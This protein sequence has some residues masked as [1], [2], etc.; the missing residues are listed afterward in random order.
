MT[1]VE[2][3]IGAAL[4]GGVGLVAAKLMGDQASNQV[5]LK[6]SAEVASM[7]SKVEGL[8]N[9]PAN[10]KS[11]LS[12][13]IISASPGTPMG[14]SGTTEATLMALGTMHVLGEANYGTFT[15]PDNGIRLERSIYGTAIT[16]LVITF[17]MN[18]S[19]I[20]SRH[21]DQIIRRIP[22][23][24]QDDTGSLTN[25]GP[26][27]KTAETVGQKKMCDSLGGAAAWNG[28]KC[29]LNQV[30]CDPGQVVTKM[31]SLGGII[32]EDISTQ[33]NLNE[34][35]DLNGVSCIGKPNIYIENTGTKLKVNCAAGACTPVNGAWSA[36]GPYGACSGGY[37]WRYRNCNNPIPSCGGASCVGSNSS[38]STT[39][40]GGCF[41]A[42][43]QIAMADGSAKNIED[44]LKGDQLQDAHSK[45][46]TVQKLLRR[47][48]WGD[49]H[50]INGGPYFFT[51]NH[52]F[53]TVEGWK[54]LAPQATKEES[55]GLD[56]GQLKT[57]DILI[58][59]NGLELILTIDAKIT[60]E[61]IYNF[62]LDAS[63]SYVADEYKVHN[64]CAAP[65]CSPGEHWY[66]CDPTNC[67][68]SCTT[69]LPDPA[70]SG[71][72]DP[73]L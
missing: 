22:F 15:I 60:E 2:L 37:K 70:C 10:C 9:N 58:K 5:Y 35:F 61:K 49:I 30:K 1:L 54:S 72:I 34:L 53:M 29:V 27:L 62:E 24:S 69:L 17:N 33:V 26:V 59:N 38:N 16:D 32:C 19:S 40:C 42:G 14:A 21:R 65:A 36:W 18:S 31:T 28:T 48:Y 25:C 13:K 68:G 46:V 39:G 47:E 67:A 6:N 64:K 12:G 73:L 63:H 11:M 56:V 43:T 23:V 51:P 55:P 44:V 41:V 66:S 52:P 3:L 50:S 8:M 71:P 4:M 57:G 20:M 45:T 7:V